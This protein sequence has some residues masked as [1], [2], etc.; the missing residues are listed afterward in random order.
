LSHRHRKSPLSKYL[1]LIVVLI[2]VPGCGERSSFDRALEALRQKKPNIILCMADDLGWGDTGFNG[3]RNIKT[4][5]LDEMASRGLVFSRFYASSPVCSPTRGSCLTGRHPYRY[6]IFGANSGHIRKEEITLAEILREQGY[7]T[8]FFG[9]WHLGTLTKDIKDSNRG[10][11]SG[12]QHF[13]PPSE[14]GFDRSFATEA[15]V[16]TYDP[17]LTPIG[18]EGNTDPDKVFGTYYWE[19]T[20]DMATD[21][22]AG[23][24]SR[25]M[26]DRALPFITGSVSEDRPFFTV[27]WFHAPHLPVVADGDTKSMYHEFTDAEQNYFGCITAMDRQMGRLREALQQLGVSD[28]TMIWFASDN[29]PEGQVQNKDRP[30][31]SGPFRGRKRSLYE[32]GIRVPAVL[33][34]PAITNGRTHTEFPAGTLD[35]LPTI[36]EILGVGLP[37]DRTLDGIS[38]L[39]LLL[40][41]AKNREDPMAFESGKQLAL[42]D[43]RYKIYSNDEGQTFE[44][45]DLL[46][47]EGEMEN[48]AETYPD[49]VREMSGALQKWR[50][51]CKASLGGEDY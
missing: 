39:P 27:I 19:E 2:A 31:S 8:G 42:M 34:W 28:N 23:D 15:K 11:P 48:L 41:N 37:D 17:M 4:P 14:H 40:G 18:W 51:S 6:G 46:N 43:D 29:G 36:L 16:P 3:N 38:L 35:Y 50:S 10:G 22:L 26:M 49:R 24:D 33:E 7:R 25:I 30:G 9:K 5:H 21:D 12:I 32:G 45:Y 1:I 47:D 44:L 13:A 20:G